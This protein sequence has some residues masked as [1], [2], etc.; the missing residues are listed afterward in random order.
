MTFLE[1]LVSFSVSYHLI[2]LVALYGL[3]VADVIT[4]GFFTVLLILLGIFT[5]L[6]LILSGTWVWGSERTNS[7]LMNLVIDVLILMY[8]VK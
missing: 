8:I 1:T 6:D 5:T 2:V 4:L 7:V 3:L